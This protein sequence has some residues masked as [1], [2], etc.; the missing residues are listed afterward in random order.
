MMA[1]TIID[2][3]QKNNKKKSSLTYINATNTSRRSKIKQWKNFN[4]A[5]KNHDKQ[6][7]SLKDNN[8]SQSS[9]AF[10]SC[11][12]PTKHVKLQNTHT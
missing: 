2:N 8:N 9:F 12:K 5:S 6:E 11:E 1:T 3:L 10:V 7:V 4:L